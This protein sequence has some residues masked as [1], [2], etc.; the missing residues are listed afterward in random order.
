V[1]KG[2]G[3]AGRA[4]YFSRGRGALCLEPFGLYSSRTD[5]IVSSAPRVSNGGLER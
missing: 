3:S 5:T 1:R 4:L 2:A